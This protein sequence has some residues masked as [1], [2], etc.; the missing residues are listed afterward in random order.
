[1]NASELLQIGNMFNKLG[2]PVTVSVDSQFP[3]LFERFC[4]MCARL[5]QEQR[6]LIISITPS[7]L[8]VLR[9]QEQSL[10]HK[11][12]HKFLA[13]I[14]TD[15]D[16]VV[17]LPLAKP[18][19]AHPKSSDAVWYMAKGLEANLRA[20]VHPRRLLFCKKA[21]D[22]G[23]KHAGP[24]KT[25]ALVDDYV[26]SGDTAMKAISS[27][28][29]KYP[30]TLQTKIFVLALVAQQEAIARLAKDGITLIA[31]QVLNRGISDNS[32]L[33]DI[34]AALQIMEKIGRKIGI[35]KEERLG[36][37]NS[38]GLVTLTR[39]PNNTFPVYWTN[40]KVNGLVWDSPF[41][42]FTDRGR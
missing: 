39:T 32:T 2:W 21:G 12:W 6:A 14:P 33:R 25:L 37:G 27:L 19:S 40:R 16:T 22:F 11:T 31:E 10:F 34:P 29:E 15:T 7:Y 18:G 35:A 38:E 23:R 3:D 30:K 42:R 41:T 8:W 1:M 9:N 4:R 28:R 20:E 17:I 24:K 36:Y 13:S 5:D 26:G